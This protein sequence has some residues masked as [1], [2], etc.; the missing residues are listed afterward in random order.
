[1][2]GAFG[3]FENLRLFLYFRI[4]LLFYTPSARGGDVCKIITI[5]GTDFP[6][7]SCKLLPY[8]NPWFHMHITAESRLQFLFD[9]LPFTLAYTSLRSPINK[10]NE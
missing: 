3:L 10:K 9:C 5:A 7:F 8:S 1:M 4:S 2:R 6:V